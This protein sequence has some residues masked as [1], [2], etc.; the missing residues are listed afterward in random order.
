M[1]RRPDATDLKILSELCLSGRITNQALAERVG[2]SAPACL[3]RVQ[4]LECKGFIRGYHADLDAQRLGFRATAYLLV[5]LIAQ[6]SS[7]I[8][9]F[10]KRIVTY[11]NVRECYALNG[12]ADFLLKCVAR[13]RKALAVL[14][15]EFATMKGVRSART[16]VVEPSAMAAPKGARRP[17]RS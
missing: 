7:A 1:A 13:D 14:A 4:R 12:E 6:T 2:I 11:P 9:D 15:E 8:A 16:L 17:T 3:R 5:T 10:E